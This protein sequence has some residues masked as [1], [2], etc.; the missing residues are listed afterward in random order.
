[1]QNGK[2]EKSGGGIIC[3]ESSPTVSKCFITQNI[4][5]VCGGGIFCQ[6]S[7]AYI[8]ECAIV[9]NAAEQCGGG[10]FCKNSA[11][12]IAKS[13]IIE[14]EV[15]GCGGGICCKESFP[16]ISNS[17][18]TTNFALTG[19][20]ISCKEGSAPIIINCTITGNFAFSYGGSILCDDE[21]SPVAINCI[22]WGNFPDE[23]F[24]LSGTP[25]VSY[26]DI[27]NGYP[28]IGNINAGP[29]FVSPE[30]RDY[31]LQ[32]GSPCID[33]GTNTGAPPEDKDGVVRPQDGNNDGILISDMGA[34]EYLSALKFIY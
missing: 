25:T 13:I 27:Q 6:E 2:T 28:G 26:S 33:S 34:Y 8:T 1:M 16:T 17:I 3:K 19:A 31:H 24:I 23:I 15:G 5:G 4:A 14:N 20:G 21:S 30:I 10:V 22:L 29:L 11:P 7:F 9:G 12:I 18:F 32:E